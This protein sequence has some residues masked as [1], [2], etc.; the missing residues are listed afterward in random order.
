MSDPLLTARFSEALVAAAQLHAGQCR[1]GT[2]IPYVS[3]LLAVA[4][5]ALEHGATEDE[6]IAALLHD[7][8]EDAPEELGAEVVRRWIR[9]QF[10]SAAL[11]IVEGCTDTDIQP[12]PPWRDR[13]ARYISHIAGASRSIVLVSAADKLHNARAIL[14]DYRRIG[15]ALWERFNAD[16]GKG[17]TIGYLRGLVSAFRATGHQSELVNELDLVVTEIEKATSIKGVWPLPARESAA[18]GR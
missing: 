13:K 14:S 15:D 12:K 5:I 1:K 3:H 8:I 6:A 4:G 2:G 9:F 10:G 17:G 11:E 7:A 16:A 18:G